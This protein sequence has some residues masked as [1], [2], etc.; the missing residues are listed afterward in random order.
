M[1][2]E[3]SAESSYRDNPN[4]TVYDTTDELGEAIAGELDEGWSPLQVIDLE[5]GADIGYRVRVEIDSE[6][7]GS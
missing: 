2:S 5:T 1:T 7:E 4:L 6:S 3:G